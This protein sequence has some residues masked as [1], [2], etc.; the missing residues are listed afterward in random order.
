MSDDYIPGK[1]ISNLQ[2]LNKLHYRYKI[3]FNSKSRATA[4]LE[5]AILKVK[6]YRTHRLQIDTA[7]RFDPDNQNRLYFDAFNKVII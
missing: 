1:P 6:R 3:C 5:Q 2:K 7:S 4:Y